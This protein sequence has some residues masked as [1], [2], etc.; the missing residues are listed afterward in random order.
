MFGTL[1]GIF[2]TSAGIVIGADTVL[3]GTSTPGPTR[4]EKTCQP[5]PRSVAALEG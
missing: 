1:I 5:S 3:W 2:I 4:A